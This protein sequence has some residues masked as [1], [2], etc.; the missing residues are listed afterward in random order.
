MIDDDFDFVEFARIVLQ[1]A[2]YEVLTASRADEGLALMRQVHPDLVLLDVVISYALDG[3][4]VIREMR[5]DP[6]L[7]GIPL[8]LISAIVSGEELDLLPKDERLKPDLFMSKPVEPTVL[9]E[10]VRQLTAAGN[11][12]RYAPE[13]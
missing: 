8:I 7:A 9:L 11:P 5:E 10:R 4:N 6:R 3:L 12:G 2:D 13:I 1:S